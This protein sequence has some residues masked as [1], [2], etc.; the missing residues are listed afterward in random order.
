MQSCIQFLF[1]DN[2][3]VFSLLISLH[4]D[5]LIFFNGKLPT[6]GT[7]EQKQ[8]QT[9]IDT[10]TMGTIASVEQTPASVSSVISPTM[11]RKTRSGS[12]DR[13][14]AP[15]TKK[16]HARIQKPPLYIK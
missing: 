9:T 11:T 13:A 2:S 10:A 15:N 5:C 14:G 16:H 1:R 4:K 3:F 6:P 12:K 7:F 8:Q